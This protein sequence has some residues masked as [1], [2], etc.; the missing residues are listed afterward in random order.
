MRLIKCSTL[1]FVEFVGAD[2]PPYAILSHT[3]NEEEIS[4][5]RYGPT[6]ELKQKKG[7]QKILRTC[8]LALR[9]RYEYAW[10]DTCCIDKSS[11]AELTEAINSMFNWYARSARCYVYL[12][13]FDGK[14]PSSDFSLCRWFTRGWT[15]QEL[16]APKEMHFYDTNWR[17]FGSKAELGAALSAITGIERPILNGMH[18]LH[19]ISVAKKM[20][21]AA[22]R[23]TTREEDLAYCLLGIFGISMPLVYGEGARAFTRLQEEIMKET[24]DLTLFA[25]QAETYITGAV[26]YR[27]VLANSPMEFSN[28]GD[29]VSNTN[30]RNNPEFAMTNKGLKIQTTLTRGLG[31][32]RFMPLNCYRQ[33]T[34]HDFIGIL[35]IN[36]VSIGGGVYA[37]DLP[38]RLASQLSEGADQGETIY[39]L[40]HATHLQH[41]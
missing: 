38:H 29:I 7:G 28:A 18:P 35:G 10:V 26:R 34:S 4:Y 1:E 20:S 32:T 23:T 31:N 24:T 13:G 33:T 40:K 25:W 22:S 6:E 30:P 17:Y 2:I 39:I 5:A 27:G 16:I 8:K 36:L 19:V 21:W 15:L 3:W 41:V 11:S 12:R 9:D 37:R 14:D